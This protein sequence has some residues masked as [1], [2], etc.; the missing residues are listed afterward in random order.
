MGLSSKI[1]LLSIALF[2]VSLWCSCGFKKGYVTTTPAVITANSDSL[3]VVS[4]DEFVSVILT[5][6]AVRKFEDF[7]IGPGAQGTKKTL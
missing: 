3:K 4:S 6:A 1:V 2:I 7:Y 5:G